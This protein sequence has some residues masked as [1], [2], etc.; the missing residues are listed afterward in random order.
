MIERDKHW[1]QNKSK[2]I[3]SACKSLDSETI[4]QQA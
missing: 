1:I 3:R 2:E 4:Y